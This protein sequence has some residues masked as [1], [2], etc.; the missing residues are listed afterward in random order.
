MSSGKLYLAF[1][2]ADGMLMA[3]LK[4]E[5]PYSEPHPHSTDEE[6]EAEEVQ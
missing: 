5:A 6:T 3:K 2:L 1:N 4:P